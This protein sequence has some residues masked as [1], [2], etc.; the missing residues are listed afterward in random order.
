MFT[1]KAMSMLPRLGKQLT[2]PIIKSRSLQTGV[3]LQKNV[4]VV[5]SGSGVY[6]GSDVHEASAVLVHLSRAGVDVSMFAP[7][8]PQV[9]TINHLKGEP[10]ESERNVL[11]E[12]AR[13]ARS[14][15]EPLSNLKAVGFDAVIFPGGFGAAKNLSSFYIDG[16]SMN[17]DEGVKRVLKEFHIAKKPIGLCCI[18][19]VLA[20]KV[21]SGCEVTVGSDKEEDGKWPYCAAAG[22]VE[23]MGAKHVIKSVNESHVDITNKIVTTPAFMC[24]TAVHVIFDGI[25]TMINGVLKLA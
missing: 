11:E 15:I 18:A 6:D 16:P 19:P 2:T 17:V 1:I 12:S 4:A 24:D 21:I 22:A 23:A 13:I 14:K 3:P 8:K 10:T 9:H 7:D 25:G 20:A 5:L